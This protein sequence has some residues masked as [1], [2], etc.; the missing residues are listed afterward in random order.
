MSKRRKPKWR[1]LNSLVIGIGLALL[2]AH[3]LPLPPLLHQF[4]L[5][6]L[7][8]L[9]YGLIGAW[10]WGNARELEVETRQRQQAER[11]QAWQHEAARAPL[12][13]RQQHFRRVTAF[14]EDRSI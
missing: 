2:L 4:L 9:G 3:Q 7:V 1:L 12:N 11:Q 14:Q 13:A 10:V 6:V 8:V 5:L